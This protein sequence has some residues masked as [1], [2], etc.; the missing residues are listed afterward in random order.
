MK[1][2]ARE[3]VNWVYFY[4]NYVADAFVL[5][6]Y[7]EMR[8]WYMYSLGINLEISLFPVSWHFKWHSEWQELF[9]HFVL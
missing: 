8:S 7:V 9:W 5:R 6:T 1:D 3:V 4:I 2:Q